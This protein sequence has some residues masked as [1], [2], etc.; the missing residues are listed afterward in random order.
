M[1]NVFQVSPCYSAI[2]LCFCFH[3]VDAFRI[4]QLINLDPAFLEGLSSFRTPELDLE[5][6]P[7]SSSLPFSWFVADLCRARGCHWQQR[8]S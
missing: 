3:G 2:G 5:K 6:C 7:F 4:F 8:A 1:N